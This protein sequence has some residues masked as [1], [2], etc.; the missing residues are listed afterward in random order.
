VFY[1]IL[2]GKL[3]VEV[4]LSSSTPALE[5]RGLDLKEFLN[6]TTIASKL[7]V[8]FVYKKVLPEEYLGNCEYIL[9]GIYFGPHISHQLLKNLT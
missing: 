3:R 2:V 5:T 9:K 4:T 1:L 8:E 6:P 7:D